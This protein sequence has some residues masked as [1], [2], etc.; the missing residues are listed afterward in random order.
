[1][2]CLAVSRDSANA[3]H[4]LGM[5]YRA[6]GRNEESAHCL[7]QAGRLGG[8]EEQQTINRLRAGKPG[9]RSLP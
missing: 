9:A 7:A 4:N 6:M 2:R 8:V 5:L 1:V 3:W